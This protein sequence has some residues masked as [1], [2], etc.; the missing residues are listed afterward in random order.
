MAK[1]TRWPSKRTAWL[2]KGGAVTHHASKQVGRFA[3]GGMVDTSAP[4][5]D[6]DDGDFNRVSMS[7]PYVSSDSPS[8]GSG[9]IST[10]APKVPAKSSPVAKSSAGGLGTTSSSD[11]A[12]TKPARGAGIGS[13]AGRIGNKLVSSPTPGP[14]PADLNATLRPQPRPGDLGSTM[15]PKPRPADLTPASKP[16]PAPAAKAPA[17]PAPKMT[18]TMTTSVKPQSRPAD[19][20]APKSRASIGGDHGSGLA[21]VTP[22]AKPFWQ[23]DNGGKKK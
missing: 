1:P 8:I 7:Q 4:N 6:N 17:K 11:T 19:L 16:A 22:A 20:G 2:S 23:T 14:R 10:S 9:P 3:S 12:P 15:K 18:T 21:P 13:D 5:D